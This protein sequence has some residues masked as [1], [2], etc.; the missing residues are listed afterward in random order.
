M[1][2]YDYKSK[3]ILIKKAGYLSYLC[4]LVHVNCFGYCRLDNRNDYH[5]TS[6]RGSSFNL[7]A[8]TAI[9]DVHSVYVKSLVSYFY[10]IER[11]WNN[12]NMLYTIPFFTVVEYF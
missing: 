8:H 5:F 7:V 6:E 12:K 11:L 3:Y 9:T 2:I 4:T 1:L 10:K